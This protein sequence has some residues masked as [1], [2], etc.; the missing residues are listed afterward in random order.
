[1]SFEGLIMKE[2]PKH[3]K[4][5]SLGAER[6]QPV[7]IAVDLIEEK[8]HELIKILTKYKEAIA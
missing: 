2:L 3:M 8:E 6:S 5:A 1:M 4:Y 7:T